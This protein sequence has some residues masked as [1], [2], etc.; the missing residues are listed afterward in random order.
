[1]N[2]KGISVGIIVT[3]ILGVIVIGGIIIAV[4]I[5]NSKGLLNGNNEEET[6]TIPMFIITKDAN[7]NP[8]E[9]D[10]VLEYKNNKG[11]RIVISEGK[12]SNAWNEIKAP[13]NYT[14]SF[15]CWNDEYYLIKGMRLKINELEIRDNKSTFSCDMSDKKGVPTISHTGN[16]NKSNN[17]IKLNISDSKWFYRTGLCFAWTSGIIDVS[18]KDQFI[19]CDKGNW[20]SFSSYDKSSKT[21]LN[22][23]SYFC[24]DNSTL[25]KCDFVEGRKCKIQSENIPSRFKGKVD[26][27]VDTGQSFSNSSIFLDLEVR[28][29]DYK[30][31]LDGITIYLYD[32][33]RRFNKESG[34]WEWVSEL[35]GKDIAVPDVKYEINYDGSSGVCNENSC[36]I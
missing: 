32:Y 1:M 21:W 28:T 4:I 20:T 12:S 26:S 13:M 29:A 34:K 6:K 36:T 24:G 33:D 7:F 11:E 8:V 30:N 25:E 17:E 9:A 18:I 35:N 5:L 22:N 16:L 14:L 10:Y 15:Y 19:N 3:I 2:K 23:N 31:S 27:C